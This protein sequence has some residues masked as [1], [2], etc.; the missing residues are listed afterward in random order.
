[1]NR[2]L[3]NERLMLSLSGMKIAEFMTLLVSFEKVLQAELCNRDRERAVGAG[4]KGALRDVRS[5]LFYILFY[6][7]VYPTYD[8]AGFVFGVDRSRCFHW[9]KR[10]LPLLEKTLGRHL[11]LPKRQIHS[12]E[13]FMALCPDVK[14]L[15]LDGT[16]RPTQRPQRSKLQKKRYSG[17]KRCHTRKN[18]LIANERR[19]I[20]FLS[21]TKGGRM[22]DLTQIKKTE[23]LR[24]FPPGK[25]LWADKAFQSI[26]KWLNPSNTVMIPHKK[27]KGK[28]LTRQQKQENKIISGIRIIVEHAINGIKRFASTAHIYRNR[29]GQDDQF[30]HLCAGLWNFHLK[31]AH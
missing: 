20:L 2:A 7:K 1:M 21:P 24:Y 29:R 3:Q 30:I 10:L 14:D 12:V 26:H 17:K 15:F 27:P 9:T 13:E 4:R 22:H 19:E 25:S 31:N 5:K 11:V 23:I 28:D 16:E 8:L 18:S 6:L